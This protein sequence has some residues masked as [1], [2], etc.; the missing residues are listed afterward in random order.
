VFVISLIS[1]LIVIF[2]MYVSTRIKIIGFYKKLTIA[3][4]RCLFFCLCVKACVKVGASKSWWVM[5]LIIIQLVVIMDSGW[6]SRVGHVGPV[7]L[8]MSTWSP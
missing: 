6:H 1:S 7:Q 2:K 5:K 4:P 8:S 3:W